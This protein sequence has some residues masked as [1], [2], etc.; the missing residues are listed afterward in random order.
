MYRDRRIAVDL[1]GDKEKND[2]PW[3]DLRIVGSHV[4]ISIRDTDLPDDPKQM[5]PVE[6]LQ[7]GHNDVVR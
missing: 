6:A 2:G 3:M 5:V 7:Q 1:H 4:Q